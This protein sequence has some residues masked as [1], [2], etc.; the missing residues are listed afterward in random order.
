MHVMKLLIVAVG[1][2]VLAACSSVPYTQRQAERLALY[3]AAAGAPVNSFRFFTLYSWEPLG[4]KTLAVYTRPN[5]AWLVDVDAGCRELPFAQ[6]IGLTSSLSQVSVRFD[7]VLTGRNNFPCTITQIRPLDVKH[8]RA[9]EQVQRQIK[10]LPRAV[11][12]PAAG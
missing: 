6:A 12:S 7:K 5:E 4:D 1:A 3:T 2:F 8:L 9:A 11:E 10:A